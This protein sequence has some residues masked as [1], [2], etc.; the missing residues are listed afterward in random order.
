MPKPPTSSG[1]ALLCALPLLLPTGAHAGTFFFPD[2]HPK[3]V[4][5]E[6]A[7]W[8]K[9]G[10][11]NDGYVSITSEVVPVGSCARLSSSSFWGSEKTQLV[12]S[13]TSNGFKTRL[14]QREIPIATFDG[15]ENG[16][17]CASLSTAPIQVVPM[18]V[19]GA[20]SL[21]NPGRLLLTVNVRSAND[22]NSD[23]VG[24]AKLLLGAA[25]LVA[26]GGTSAIV[27][28]ASA[29]VGNAVLSDTEA[30]ANKLMKGMTDAR[31]PISLSWSDLRKGLHTIEIPVYRADQMGAVTDKQIQQLQADP[32]SEKIHL[33]TIRLDFAFSRTLFYP[34]V[35]E[36]ADLGV[37]ENI[38]AERI[39]NHPVPGATDNFMQL[40]NSAAPSQ[41][42][43]LG[44]ASGTELTRACAQG[45][46]KLRAAGL[47]NP[48][49]ALVMK[50]FMDEARGNTAW[51]QD[52]AFVKACF[53]QAPKVASALELVYGQPGAAP[54]AAP[55]AVPVLPPTTA[56]AAESVATPVAPPVVE[57]TAE[58]KA[59]EQN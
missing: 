30:R 46:E 2:M 58:D 29:V 33:F 19:L 8:L 55:A 14:D 39:L 9:D 59:P 34:T 52:P 17:E 25:T 40:L 44:N 51:Y 37:R 53:G 48:D 4:R 41:L 7:N 36:L 42:R 11:G 22:S 28:G 23:F 1:I 43:I 21:L 16:A 49:I 50:S 18:A 6:P 32:N 38:S 35:E 47:A 57:T 31:V 15:R 54:A 56:P 26:S 3:Q 5:T 13:V 27:G 45:F 20:R 12:L 10:A 24:S